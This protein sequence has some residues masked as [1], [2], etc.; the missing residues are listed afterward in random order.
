MPPQF[1]TLP[2]TLE[3]TNSSLC[4]RSVKVSVTVNTHIEISWTYDVSRGVPALRIPKPAPPSR[5]ANADMVLYFLLTP[6]TT[7]SPQH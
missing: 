4:I 1:P 6:R 7:S 2:R 5:P 3:F